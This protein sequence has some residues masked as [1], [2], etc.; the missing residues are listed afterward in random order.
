MLAFG[1][2]CLDARDWN[3]GIPFV[4]I[5]AHK[6]LSKYAADE[7]AYW[8]V[9]EVWADVQAVYLPCLKGLPENPAKRS[10]YCQ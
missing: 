5:D 3:S 9:P 4:L 2:E 10:E 7:A 6:S 1:H 8:Q